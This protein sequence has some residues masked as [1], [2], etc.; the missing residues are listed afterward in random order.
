M[1]PLSAPPGRAVV[2]KYAWPVP[3]DVVDVAAEASVAA[4]SEQELY[5]VDH[6]F[7]GR[8]GPG[9]SC[10]VASSPGPQVIV[11]RFRAPRSIQTVLVES[12]ERSESRVQ[13]IEIVAF[14]EREG[15]LETVFEGAPQTFQYAPYQASFHRAT[16]T[17]A[18]TDVTELHVRVFPVPADRRASLTSII[19]R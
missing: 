4:T 18:A 5:P 1:D 7:D 9:G 3:S 19:P 6:L 13:R 10:W 2:R 12:E 17:I 11:L 14:R 8:S 15:T 16:W